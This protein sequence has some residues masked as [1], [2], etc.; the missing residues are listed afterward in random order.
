MGFLN[1]NSRRERL[2]LDAIRRDYPLPDVIAGAGV[3]LKRKGNELVGLCPFHSEK[4]P[5]FTVFNGG[6]RFHCF[7]CG[8]GG[9]VLD[10]VQALHG[11]GLRE[12]GELL[13]GSELPVVSLP[14]PPA[15]DRADRTGDAV[16]I[17]NAASPIGGTPAETYLRGRAIR[18]PLPD[19]LRF[20]S[21]P[22][23]KRG[24]EHPCLVAAISD[25]GGQIVGI[26]R[27]YLAPNGKGKAD[28][29]KAKLS[30][31]RVTGGAVRLTPPARTLIFCEGVEDALSIIQCIGRAAWATCGT[32]N[33]GKVDFPLMCEEIVIGADNDE[34]GEAAAQKAARAYAERGCK[35]RII[36]P[37]PGFNDFNAELQEAR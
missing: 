11:V 20:A 10:F 25:D 36:R 8:T 9:D 27:T 18:M 1:R 19:S 17:W 5:S 34:P 33:L 14:P 16:A 13:G 35:V 29:P 21:L 28:V 32:S 26:Q 30:L 31:G 22:Y 23:G 24:A 3:V 7:G 12:A 2:D 15:A 6:Q 4:S 37:L